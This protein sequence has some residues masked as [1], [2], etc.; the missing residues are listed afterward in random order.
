MNYFNLFDLP[1]AFDIDQS[2]LSRRFQELQRETHPDRFAHGTEQQK[3]QAVQVAT[4]INQAYQALRKP[5]SRAE[6]LLSLHGIDIANEQ[7]TMQ[8]SAFLM[9]Q[10][11]LREQLDILEAKGDEA[12]LQS[13]MLILN[14]LEQDLLQHISANLTASIWNEAA[15]A[16]RKLRF[17]S[18]LRAQAE[19]LEETLLDF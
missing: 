12:G 5:L 1:Q 15:C 14:Q 4:T 16:V 6:Y 13:F 9:Q 10:L 19:Q 7:Q 11:E 3:L 18:R 8:D 2:L 17:V